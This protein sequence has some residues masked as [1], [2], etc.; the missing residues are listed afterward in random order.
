MKHSNADKSVSGHGVRAIAD[1]QS[2]MHEATQAAM[3]AEK[4]RLR[5][6]LRE[7]VEAGEPFIDNAFPSE[8]MTGDG[9]RLY[10][11]WLAAMIDAR[12]VGGSR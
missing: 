11:R 3:Q 8:Q 1:A 10:N 4:A 2:A 6:A 5:Q 7:L 9:L 12:R